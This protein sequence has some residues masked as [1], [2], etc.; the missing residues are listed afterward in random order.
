MTFVP[1]QSLC[2]L[3]ESTKSFLRRELAGY[4]IDRDAADQLSCHEG[5]SQVMGVS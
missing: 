3:N 1:Q 2:A 4:D 5:A